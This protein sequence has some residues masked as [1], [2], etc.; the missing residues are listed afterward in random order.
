MP[1]NHL[2]PAWDA[3]TGTLAATG[4][5]AAERSRRRTGEG[6]VCRLAL[7]DVAFAMVGH[8]GKIAEVQI[9]RT[10]RSKTGN[11]LYGAFGRDFTT[12]DGR[13]L[14]VVALTPKQWTS[15]R[16]A[17]RLDEA[18]AAIGTLYGVDLQTEGGRFAA[19]DGLAAALAAW[20]GAR[21]YADVVA[22]FDRA[23]VCWGPYQ[24]FRELVED[25]P[26]CSELNPM[27][28]TVDQPGIGEYLAPGSPLAFSTSARVPV[29]PAPQIGEHTEEILAD[30]VGLSG[31]EIG[32]LH[33]LGVV[34]S[35]ERSRVYS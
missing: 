21:P 7:S 23:G 26:R 32:E 22:T 2:L 16:T 14:M 5:L 19:R 30:V 31:H 35:S 20:M 4:L 13:R 10:E 11:Y 6:Q 24:T 1:F 15:L 12:S 18:F 33:D 34:A 3:I 17:T 29:R 8:L 27:F 9:N 28:E 25:D